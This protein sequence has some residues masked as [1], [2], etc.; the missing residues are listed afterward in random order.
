MLY[1]SITI[2]NA[3]FCPDCN[4]LSCACPPPLDEDALYAE[5]YAY[6]YDACLADGY[7]NHPFACWPADE[8][9]A[10]MARDW[11]RLVTGGSVRGVD[12]KP[13][14]AS[15]WFR[16]RTRWRDRGIYG[17]DSLRSTPWPE[18]TLV[19]WDDAGAGLPSAVDEPEHYAICAAALDRY[20]RTLDL[21][22]EMLAPCPLASD[23]GAF[24]PDSN[25]EL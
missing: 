6:G 3:S 8:A 20:E 7:D 18:A 12:G 14:Y 1:N 21:S 11:L 15:H 4:R 24:R 2:D 17:Y 10:A 22:S 16:S 23:R 5:H 19:G 13:F 9:E 25:P